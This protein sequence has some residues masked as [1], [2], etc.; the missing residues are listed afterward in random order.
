MIPSVPAHGQTSIPDG[1]C[2]ETRKRP[3]VTRS[4]IV[5]EIQVV[6]ENQGQGCKAVVMG[7]THPPAVPL[8]SCEW[9]QVQDATR[10]WHRYSQVPRNWNPFKVPIRV[11][12]LC[13][14]TP[15]GPCPGGHPLVRAVEGLASSSHAH[16][17][18]VPLGIS[19]S[20]NQLDFLADVYCLSQVLESFGGPIIALCVRSDTPT[21]VSTRYLRRDDSKAGITF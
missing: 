1:D 21:T 17:V 5:S 13:A 16:A 19:C 14:Q 20:K 18:W 4:K 2:G 15:P 6:L 3:S 12:F 10:L 9:R 11:R 7:W 8:V